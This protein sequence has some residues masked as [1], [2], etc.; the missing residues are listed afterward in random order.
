MKGCRKDKVR[1]EARGVR[2]HEEIKR[3]G[4]KIGNE[5]RGLFNIRLL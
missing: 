3:I 2:I 5:R 1:V 4:V